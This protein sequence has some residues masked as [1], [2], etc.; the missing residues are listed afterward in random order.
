MEIGVYQDALCFS[1]AEYAQKSPDELDA[2]KAG[3]VLKYIDLIKNPPPEV[4]PTVAEL[5]DFKTDLEA[6]LAQVIEEIN[7]R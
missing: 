3:R 6:Q 1:Q 2:I 4:F 7:N 5:E